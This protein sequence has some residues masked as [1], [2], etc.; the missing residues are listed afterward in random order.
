MERKMQMLPADSRIST[1][2]RLSCYIDAERFPCTKFE[3][4][5]HAEEGHAPDDILDCIED[6]DAVVVSCMDALI[7]CFAARSHRVLIGTK[8]VN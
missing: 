3:L 5:R 8:Y 2:K 4:L 7:D 1:A 6:M